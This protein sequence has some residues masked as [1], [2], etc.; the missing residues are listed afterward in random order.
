MLSTKVGRLLAPDATAPRDQ[1]GYV[2]RC[3]SCSA[4]TT[5][6]TASCARSTTACSGSAL[7]RIDVVFIHD[8]DATTHGAA[9]ARSLARPARRRAAGAGGAQGR[10]TDRAATASASTTC[11]S[12]STCSPPRTSTCSCSRGATRCR[13]ERARRAAAAVRSAAASRS[14][15]GGPVQLRASSRPARIRRDGSGA[16]FQLRAGAAGRRRAAWRAIEAVCARV[17]RAAARPRRCNSRVAHP[18]RRRACSRARA[19]VA[20]FDE[21]PALA[22][23]PIP[24]A[25]W[26]ALRAARASIEAAPLPRTSRAFAMIDMRRRASPRLVARTRRLRLAHARAGA[27]PSRLHARRL[28][29]AAAAAGVARDVLVQ[30]APTRGRDELPAAGA[31]KASEGVVRRRRR[32][33]RPR[34]R[35]PSTRWR[36]SRRDPL[37]KSVRPML[38]DLADPAWI[39]RPT[40]HPHS[41]P[42]CRRSACASMRW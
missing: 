37:L 39:L 38:Q 29:A 15:L 13:P 14:S 17:R 36:R 22:R 1:H 35:T 21:N 2:M 3:R 41:W 28:C 5:P 23:H 24:P 31:R 26:Q 11:R 7:A 6:P 18:G 42:R 33:G 4:T 10:R 16:V 27:D 30:A 34:A 32:L 8:I 40:V 19:A 12:A 9:H 20:E 25:F